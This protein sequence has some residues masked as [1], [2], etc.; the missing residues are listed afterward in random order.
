ML[1]RPDAARDTCEGSEQPATD[2]PPM[3]DNTADWPRPGPPLHASIPG[4]GTSGVIQL[5]CQIMLRQ[6]EGQL[7]EKNDERQRP[8]DQKCREDVERQRREDQ[9]HLRQ[10]DQARQ[11]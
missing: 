5:M 8:K 7:Q 4:A 1:E 6:R 10:E 2:W 9:M 11:Q 3:P